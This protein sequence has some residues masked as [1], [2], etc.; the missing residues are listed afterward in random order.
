MT[1]SFDSRDFIRRNGSMTTMLL[2]I[3]LV[4]IGEKMAERFLPLYQFAIGGST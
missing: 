1:D 4:G 2:L 3:I